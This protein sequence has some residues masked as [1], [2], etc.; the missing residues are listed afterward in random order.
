MRPDHPDRVCVRQPGLFSRSSSRMSLPYSF[1]T[2]RPEMTSSGNGEAASFRGRSRL[3]ESPDRGE[4]THA[5]GR[6]GLPT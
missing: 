1:Q 3:T 2:S 6:V 5:R 4:K